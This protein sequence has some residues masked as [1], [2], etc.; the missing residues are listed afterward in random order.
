MEEE[1]EEIKGAVPYEHI[2]HAMMNARTPAEIDYNKFSDA[3]AWGILKAAFAIACVGFVMAFMVPR[4]LL[5]IL[6]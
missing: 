6:L 2:M 1:T 5:S 3:V 4:L